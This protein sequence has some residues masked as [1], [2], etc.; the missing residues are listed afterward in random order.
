[1]LHASSGAERAARIAAEDAAR[2]A[3]H[4]IA[5]VHL[6]TLGTSMMFRERRV[7]PLADFQTDKPTP[8]GGNRPRRAMNGKPPR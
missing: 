4:A 8:A 7:A 1:M 6:G 3:T 2:Q 5:H